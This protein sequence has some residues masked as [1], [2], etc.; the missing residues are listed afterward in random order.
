MS[1]VNDTR[2]IRLPEKPVFVD[3]RGSRRRAVVVAGIAIGLGLT[4][5]LVLIV[6]SLAVVIVT[7]PPTAGGG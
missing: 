2:L 4:G 5:W 3:W 7:G 1:D 6:A